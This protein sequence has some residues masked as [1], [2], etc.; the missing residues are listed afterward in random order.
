MT[1]TDVGMS[2]EILDHCAA[3]TAT[4]DRENRFF[5]EDFEELRRAGYLLM[6]VPKEFGGQGLTLAEVCAE[7]RRLAYRS[8]A[9]ALAMNMHVYW[10]GVAA[11]LYRSGDTSCQWILEED[12]TQR[13][14]VVEP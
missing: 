12:Q 8:P 1:M 10:T 7:E 11:D 4:Y 3:R 6:A 13:L 14:Y 5:D 9:T 2:E